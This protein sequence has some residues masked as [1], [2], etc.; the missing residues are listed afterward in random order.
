MKIV[1]MPRAALVLVMMPIAAL[2]AQPPDF[3]GTWALDAARSRISE[4]A[5]LAGLIPA[6]APAALHITQP[7]NGT[8]VIESQINEGHARIY[9]PRR[10]SSTPAGQGGT[11]TMTSRWDGRTLI[12]EGSQESPSGASAPENAARQVKEVMTLSADGRTLTIEVTTT[13]PVAG[14][15]SAST[16][17]YTRAQGVGHCSSWPTPCKT[18]K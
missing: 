16:L 8:L 2:L 15:R 7:A 9:M 11:I 3:S 13:G 18:W 6:G 14:Q 4:T 12:S 17:M 5:G 1:I 10:K